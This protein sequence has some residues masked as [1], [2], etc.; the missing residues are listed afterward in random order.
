MADDPSSPELQPVLDALVDPDCRAIL[1]AL[2]E[3]P[4]QS[5][6]ELAERCD[7]P[8][9]TAYRKVGRLADADLVDE[10]TEVRSDG[11]HTTVYRAAVEGVFVGL[12]DAEFGVEVARPEP[13]D[14]RLARFWGAMRDAR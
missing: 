8:D 14:E 12:E 11:H 6:G 10:T 9:T 2:A 5:V 4:E 13:A 7:L 1:A 3:T